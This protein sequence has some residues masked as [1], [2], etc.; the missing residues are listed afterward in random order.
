M[1]FVGRL[2]WWLSSVAGGG[3]SCACNVNGNGNANCNNTTETFF[4]APL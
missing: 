4:R 3:T 1:L 2:S